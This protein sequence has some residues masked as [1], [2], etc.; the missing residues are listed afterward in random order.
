MQ[1]GGGGGPHRQLP[2]R[3]AQ[4]GHA[5]QGHRQGGRRLATSHHYYYTDHH[6]QLVEEIHQIHAW[7]DADRSVEYE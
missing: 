6:T 2:H 3:A 5:H 7:I 4:A 1:V